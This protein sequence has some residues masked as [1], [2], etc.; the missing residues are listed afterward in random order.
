[1]KIFLLSCI[2]LAMG[3]APPPRPGPSRAQLDRDPRVAEGIAWLDKHLDRIT[4]QQIRLTEI[5]A[6]TDHESDRALAVLE[7]LQASGLH[8]TLDSAGNV[9]AEWPGPDPKGVVL[10]CAHLDTV[11][12][13][14]T[15][16]RVR[17][18]KGLLWAPG[19]SDNGAGLAALVAV[20]RA[21]AE[22]RLH[23]HLT[24][25]FAADV[26]EEGEGNLRGI[27]QL[28]E[29][30]RPRLRAVIAVEGASA[31][32]TATKGLGSRRI[33]AIVTGP[34]GHSWSD[35]GRPN[36]IDAL[37]RG[38]AHFL[39]TPLPAEP[40]STMN[41]GWI[42]GG[43]SVNSIPAEASVKVD[44]RSASETQLE[45]IEQLFRKTILAGVEAE[46]NASAASGERLVARFRVMGVRPGGELPSD[47]QLFQAIQQVDSALGLA[48]RFERASTDANLPLSLGIPAVAIGGG[49]SGG[50]AHSL[51]EW[52]DPAGRELA[53]KRLLL[54]VVATAGLGS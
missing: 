30:Y 1:V 25:I 47:S 51:K 37:A 31:D 27:R 45:S 29:T 35:F 53:L 41:V 5:P 44:I 34:G 17:R 40:R 48:T 19:I 23:T 3:A 12:P 18:E 43:T 24:V 9:V 38:I 10:V 22:T 4:E 39:E 33:E 26:G 13:P 50:G 16:V 28:I 11:F 2:L 46:S 21:V 49:G 54:L 42:Q 32:F 7:L 6:P 52:Y 8:A 36:P 20:A 15:A 14:G